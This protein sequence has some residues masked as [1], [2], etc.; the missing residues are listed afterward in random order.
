MKI[1]E[2]IKSTFVDGHHKAMVNVLFTYNWLNAIHSS[3]LKPFGLSVQQF[4]VLRILKGQ[5]PKPASVKL[6]SERMIDKNSNA[7][8]LVDK[9]IVKDYVK[10][11]YCE[12]DRRQVDIS[13][14]KTGIKELE[15]A[16]AATESL[17]SQIGLSEKEA[18]EL[19]N[20]LDKLR[21]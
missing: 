13:I 21:S 19:S 7:S 15:K 18:F 9:L 12:H 14:T 11:T 8:R 17:S 20:L 10:R 4:N 16:S 3:L 1:E 2:E 6:I 5:H